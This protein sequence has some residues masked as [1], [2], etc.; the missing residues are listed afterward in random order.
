[1]SSGTGGDPSPHS[2]SWLLLAFGDERQHEG[3]EGYNDDPAHSY[4][5]DNF[6]PNSRQIREGDLVLIRDASALLGLARIVTIVRDESH[7]KTVRRCPACMKTTLKRRVALSP[8]YR[9]HSCKAEFDV[10]VEEEIGCTAFEARFGSTFISTPGTI[11]LEALRRACPAYNRQLAMQR[12]A[13]ESIRAELLSGVPAVGALLHEDGRR[14]ENSGG[15]NA[16]SR[17]LEVAQP[18][19]I[20]ADADPRELAIR[21]IRARRGQPAFR[22]AL[23][24]RFGD[25]C[26]VTGCSLV[27]L[28]EAAHILPYRGVHTQ[29]ETNGLL[30][31]AD[32]HTLFDLDLMGIHP[33]SLEVQFHPAAM[34]AGY[35][36]LAGRRL[37]CP[38]GRPD[39]AALKARWRRFLERLRM[40]G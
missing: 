4:R 1:M 18:I 3:N 39:P 5:Y 27:E 24:R 33:A 37:L 31:R 6:V 20:D 22:E 26:A 30:L 25:R 32:I 34:A 7:R 15:E 29:V 8:P 10:P 23:R 35:S 2:K 9:C 21:Q 14:I 19:E 40:P 17:T 38:G 13:L 36:T 28:L 11:S 12:I 16:E